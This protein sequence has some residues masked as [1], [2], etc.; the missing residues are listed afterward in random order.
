MAV[1]PNEVVEHIEFD[2]GLATDWELWRDAWAA[3]LPRLPSQ[4]RWMAAGPRPYGADSTAAPP[5]LPPPRRALHG[6]AHGTTL[7][8]GR[9]RRQSCVP[10]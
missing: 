3:W 2:L 7:K 6:T 8:E 5:P 10:A 4:Y 9:A 1:A